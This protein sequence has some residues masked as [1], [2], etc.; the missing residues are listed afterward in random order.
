MNSASPRVVAGFGSKQIIR[1]LGIFGAQT[2]PWP[3]NGELCE[4]TRTGA[5]C[6]QASFRAVSRRSPGPLNITRAS[7]RAGIPC[8]GQTN[9]RAVAT[10]K[11]TRNST[12]AAM[13]T[14]HFPCRPCCQ[15]A[16]NR[17]AGSILINGHP[18]LRSTRE[19]HLATVTVELTLIFHRGCWLRSA[20]CG[21]C[22]G[23][24]AASRRAASPAPG[25]APRDRCPGSQGQQA[26]AGLG[27]QVA[28]QTVVVGGHSGGL[29]LPGRAPTVQARASG[30]VLVILGAGGMDD[31]H[32]AGR[33][34]M[35]LAAGQCFAPVLRRA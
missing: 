20:G 6:I 13:R 14:R 16:L 33:L 10:L 35:P 3:Q 12:A 9:K 11:A 5:R 34:G 30:R 18:S 8:A 1:T 28:S 26:A 2:L 21:R 4:I 31:L 32:P 22:S 17:R 23:P 25:A 24:G 7:T 15:T 29:P 27:G 19:R